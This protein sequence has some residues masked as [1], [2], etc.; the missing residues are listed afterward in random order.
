M[1]IAEVH[2][3][4]SFCYLQ[5]NCPQGICV[6]RDEFH[7]SINPKNEQDMKMEE[8]LEKRRKLLAEQHCNTR[9]DAIDVVNEISSK[10]QQGAMGIQQMIDEITSAIMNLKQR[11]PDV[12]SIK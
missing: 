10:Y 11:E 1:Q 12:N 2:W 9:H 8:F 7:K 6:K 4:S 3:C 5:C